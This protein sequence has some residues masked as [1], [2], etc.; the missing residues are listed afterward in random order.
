M[1]Q[2]F[3][4]FKIGIATFSLI[5]LVLV[6]MK[7]LEMWT[8]KIY[9]INAI[10]CFLGWE[11]WMSLGVLG[12]AAGKSTLENISNAIAMS[13]GDGLIGVLQI[14]AVKK[15]FGVEAFKT[16]DWKVFSVIFAIGVSQNILLGVAIQ[17]RL[18]KRKISWSPMMP[19]PGPSFL[20]NQE[21]WII[22]PFILYGILI[23]DNQRIFS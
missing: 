3:A 14:Y 1:I 11:V 16:W 2:V 19:V 10:L 17:K 22:Q 7:K 4:M 21:S 12:D 8:V 20:V 6:A 13:A 23:W 5:L 9:L 18:E 15:S